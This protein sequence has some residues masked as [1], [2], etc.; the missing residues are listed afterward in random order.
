[1]IVPAGFFLTGNFD[2][3]FFLENIV[4]VFFWNCIIWYLIDV[5]YYEKCFSRKRDFY[6]LILNILKAIDSEMFDQILTNLD[7]R[8]WHD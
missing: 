2:Q 1:L 3:Y 6:I 4:I 8:E 7:E 5:W